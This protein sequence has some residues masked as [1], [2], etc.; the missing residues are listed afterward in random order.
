MA[1]RDRIKELKRVKARELRPNPYNWRKHPPQQ[2]A[3]MRGILGEVGYVDALLVRE[4]P[5]G[6]YEIVDGHLRAEIDPNQD[7]PILVLD[8]DADEAAKVLATFDPLG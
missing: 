2:L 5:D 3:A 6:A 1:I 7:V 8:I 4:L